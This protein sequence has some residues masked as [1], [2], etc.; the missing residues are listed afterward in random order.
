[1]RQDSET[2]SPGEA[3]AAANHQ[4]RERLMWLVE[5]LR[6]G[7][8]PGREQL[9]ERMEVNVRT[10][11]RLITFLRDRLGAPVVYDRTLPGYRLTEPTWFLP[12]MSVTEGELFSLLVAKQAMAQYRGTPVE[13]S[14]ERIFAKIAGD[15][16]RNITVHPEYTRTN[17][18]SFAPAP[19]L[20]VN[21]SVWNRLLQAAE[22]RQWARI[23]YRSVRSRETRPRKVAPHHIL[24]MQG[25]W[26][27]FAHDEHHGKICQFQLHRIE[28]V[29]LLGTAFRPDPDF[30]IEEVISNSF[31]SFGACESLTDLHIRITGESAALLRDRVFHPAQ[32]TTSVPG[33]FEIRFPVSADGD[34]PFY[35][36]IQWLLSMGRDVKILDPPEL[37]QRMREEIEA[38]RRQL[39]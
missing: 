31:G 21:E 19:V 3:P 13:K 9:A 30:S 8:C 6:D 15:L 28:T 5:L 11:Q 17:V 36:I 2:T 29:T 18:L 12:R 25:D 39:S 24:N 7:T 33:G 38:M 22:S 26:Y 34:R 37:R 14:L 4:Q 35:H 32:T 10:I 20:P 16:G 23:N 27:L 1:M